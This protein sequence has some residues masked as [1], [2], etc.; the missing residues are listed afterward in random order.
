MFNILTIIGARPQIIKS[1]AISRM[2]KEKY[3]D[4]FNECILHTGQH[5]DEK[6][7]AVFFDELGISRPDYN[8][9][10][11][12]G[13]H[14]YQTGEM[15]KGIERVLA[16]RHF[17]AL[18]VYG[19]TNSTIAGALVGVKAGVPVV[20][21]EAGLRSYDKR[22]PEELNRIATDHISSLLFSPTETGLDN[23]R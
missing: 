15:M 6:M 1:I 3:S 9:N 13:S 18:I 21:V 14:A 23:L 4:T 12:G 5:Y 17:D 7:S 19:D 16:E 2:I 8:L 10:V 11:R 20:H 22:M